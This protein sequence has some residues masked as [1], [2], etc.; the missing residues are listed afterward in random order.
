[1]PPKIRSNRL[2]PD[3]IKVQTPTPRPTPRPRR[4]PITE[5]TPPQEKEITLTI[6]YVAIQLPVAQKV[7]EALATHGVIRNMTSSPGGGG[8][9][10]DDRGGDGGR[11]GA[12]KQFAW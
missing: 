1:M 5:L 12:R 11:G 2:N 9:R 8:G 6:E 3:L 10:S 7:T 4:K